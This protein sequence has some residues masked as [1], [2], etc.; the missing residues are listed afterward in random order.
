MSYVDQIIEAFGG[1]RP[2][3]SAIG[4]RPSTVQS[5]KV[6]RSIP[7]EQKVHIWEKA[8]ECGVVLRPEQFVPFE[9]GPPSP[10]E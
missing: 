7:D 2:M 6:R 5:W 8:Q 4:K 10:A 9:Q 3:A 1:I